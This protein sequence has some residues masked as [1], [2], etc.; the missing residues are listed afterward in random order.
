MEEEEEEAEWP[1]DRGVQNLPLRIELLDEDDMDRERFSPIK[2]VFTS[3]VDS[4]FPYLF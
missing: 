4:I 3:T 2:E 1:F